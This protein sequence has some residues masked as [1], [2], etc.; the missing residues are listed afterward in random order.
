MY[1][2]KGF[3]GSN[4]GKGLVQTAIQEAKSRFHDIAI[5]LE[6]RA[7]NVKAFNLYKKQDFKRLIIMLR[8]HQISLS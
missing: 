8:R 1:V 5:G 2:K 4:I 3:Q 6:V 7:D